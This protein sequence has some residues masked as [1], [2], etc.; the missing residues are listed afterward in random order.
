MQQKD[1]FSSPHYLIRQYQ[2]KLGKHLLYSHKREDRSDMHAFLQ[3]TLLLWYQ[4]LFSYL[5][6]KFKKS[7]LDALK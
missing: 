6:L 1:V 3:S 5:Y 2:I 4:Y 7:A